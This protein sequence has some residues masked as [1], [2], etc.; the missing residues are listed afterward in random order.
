MNLDSSLPDMQASLNATVDG[1]YNNYD[2]GEVKLSQ[3]I[4]LD[5]KTITTIVS[6]IQYKQGKASL[7]N[8]GTV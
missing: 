8:L 3:P 4:M 1:G 5:G 2:N 6:Q 7:R